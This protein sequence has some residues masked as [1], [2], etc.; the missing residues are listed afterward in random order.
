[1][2]DDRFILGL[3]GIVPALLLLTATA[4]IMTVDS[5]VTFIVANTTNATALRTTE[6]VTI[7]E[8]SATSAESTAAAT[9]VAERIAKKLSKTYTVY[10]LKN[11]TGE[12]CYVGRVADERFYS[13]MK[14]HE[15]T[16]GLTPAHC[17]QGLNYYE[18]RGLEE[19]GMIECHTLR[20]GEF[21]YNQIHGISTR[22]SNGEK[23]MFDALSYLEN[24]AEQE[25]LNLFE[26]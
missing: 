10:F 8:S 2:L 21:R 11:C 18:A 9:I 7:S 12:I 16:K 20:P 26:W 13:R 5:N 17:V 19:I 4:G 23:Y 24:K 15:N 25:L 1:M 22:N 6:S 14:Y 3:G